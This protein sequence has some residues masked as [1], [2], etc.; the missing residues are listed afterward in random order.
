MVSTHW[1]DEFVAE[2]PSGTQIKFSKKIGR[3]FSRSQNLRTGQQV[4]PRSLLNLTAVQA[5]GKFRSSC[6][7]MMASKT[8][9]NRKPHYV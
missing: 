8:Y 4:L 3:S 5:R 1:T 2:S 7:I 9:D 6:K